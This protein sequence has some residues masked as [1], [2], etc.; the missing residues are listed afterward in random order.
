M[1]KLYC[2]V[3]S[4]VKVLVEPGLLCPGKLQCCWNTR[5][6]VTGGGGSGGGNGDSWLDGSSETR[7]FILG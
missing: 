6:E 2:S 3:Q 5:L 4:G 1:K 7:L